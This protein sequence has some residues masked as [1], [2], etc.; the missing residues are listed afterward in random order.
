MDAA[1]IIGVAAA[2]FAALMG[3]GGYFSLVS[4][5]NETEAKFLNL[6]NDSER[7]RELERTISDLEERVRELEILNQAIIRLNADLTRKLEKSESVSD[8]LS[9][10]NK[11]LRQRIER[12]MGFTER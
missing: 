6:R 5:R 2:L 9:E 8:V 3:V 11:Q 4:Y 12:A 1:L 10:E 7:V